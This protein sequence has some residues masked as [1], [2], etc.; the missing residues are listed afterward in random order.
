MLIDHFSYEDLVEVVKSCT[1]HS[2]TA[3]T[4]YDSVESLLEMVQTHVK[5]L[6]W[7]NSIL[8]GESFITERV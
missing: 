4:Y 2:L 1:S 8:I 7:I 6:S 5:Q 3:A